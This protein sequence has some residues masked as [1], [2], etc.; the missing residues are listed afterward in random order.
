LYGRV[1][2][3]GAAKQKPQLAKTVCGSFRHTILMHRRVICMP[4]SFGTWM[5]RPW[6]VQG[7]RAP[8]AVHALVLADLLR[9]ER[10]RG[11]PGTEHAPP[12]P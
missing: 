10:E 2:S 5:W 11:A 7:Y 1:R 9:E 8:V 6:P 4:S 12:N 3:S